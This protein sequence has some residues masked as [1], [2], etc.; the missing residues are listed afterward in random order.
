MKRPQ[1]A[2]AVMLAAAAGSANAAELAISAGQAGLYG[3]IEIGDAPPPVLVYPEPILVVPPPVRVEQPP[4]YLHVPPEHLKH[5]QKYCRKYGAC[6]EPAY[7]VDERWYSEVYQ[8][9][10]RHQQPRHVLYAHDIHSDVVRARVIYAHDVHADNV[11]ARVVYEEKG[12]DKGPRG[13][14]DIDA[15]RVEADEIDAH[16]IHARRVEAD[17]LYVHKL[18]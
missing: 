2:A 8:P 13:G 12:K 5:W 15:P 3:R 18:K 4:I 1:L 10:Y 7:F 11:Q 16:D 17:T 6:G 14:D 9:Y